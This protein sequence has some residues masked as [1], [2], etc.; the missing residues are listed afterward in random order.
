MIRHITIAIISIPKAKVCFLVM[1]L[2]Y[3]FYNLII[4]IKNPICN[5]LCGFVGEFGIYNK[6][7]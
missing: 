2:Y 5:Q 4:T 7:A 6:E 1:Y 3:N